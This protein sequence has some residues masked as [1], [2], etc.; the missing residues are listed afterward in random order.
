MDEVAKKGV[1]KTQRFR[2]PKAVVSFKA[3]IRHICNKLWREEWANLSGHRQS[4]IFCDGLI[5]G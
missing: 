5:E 2:T 3:K 1:D 4:K